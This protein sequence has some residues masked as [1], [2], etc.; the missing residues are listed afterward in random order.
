MISK[1]N[2]RKG[3]IMDH[4]NHIP[5][6]AEEINHANI[7]GANVYGPDD[8][9]IGSVSHFHGNGASAQVVVD[10]GGF[11]GIGAKPVGLLV[12]NLNFMRDENGKV[13]ATTAM[14]KDQLKDLP[15][16]KHSHA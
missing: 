15:E 8:H 16:H 1:F 7:E 9:N 5:L 10:V 6:R 3:E 2:N 13:H 14:T 11:L 12:G 4:T